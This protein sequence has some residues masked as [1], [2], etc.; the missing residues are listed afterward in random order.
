MGEGILVDTDYL[1]EYVKGRKE[2]P[3]SSIYYISEVTVYEFIRGTRDPEE[4]K[5]ILEDMFSVIWADNEVLKLA[6]SIW[7][8]LKE[9]G[10]S[11]D[12]RDIVIGAMA[13]TKGLKLLTLNERHFERLQKY[14]LELWR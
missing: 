13:V 14:G 10:K 1:I 6:A 7:A 8:S 4:A 9:E 12:D 5:E 11:L 3:P 2:L